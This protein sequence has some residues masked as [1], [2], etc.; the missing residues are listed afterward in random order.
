MADD[1]E[2]HGHGTLHFQRAEVGDA[3]LDL[4]RELNPPLADNLAL[5]RR[6]PDLSADERR[7]APELQRAVEAFGGWTPGYHAPGDACATCGGAVGPLFVDRLAEGTL[8][9]APFVSNLPVHPTRSC[10]EGLRARRPDLSP[11]AV[12][13]ARRELTKDLARPSAGMSQFFRHDLLLHPP[14]ALEDWVGS[15]VEANPQGLDKATRKD[16][17]RLLQWAH[18]RLFHGH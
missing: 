10:L 18:A 13:Q 6:W 15:V 7:R 1:H 4:L 14:F 2:E 17:D 9:Y 3:T 8:A 12:D 11:R 5:T 16:M